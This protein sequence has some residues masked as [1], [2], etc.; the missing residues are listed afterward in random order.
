MMIA[1]VKGRFADINGV[2]KGDVTNPETFELDVTID[3]AS[4][5]TRQDQRDAH[6]RSPDFFDVQ[7]WPT[8]RFVGK[9][10]EGDPTGEFTLV[11]D[12]TIRDVTR[13]LRLAV[14]NEGSVVDPW[15]N[16][17]LGFSANGKIKRSDFGLT[18]NQVLEAGGLAVGD[19]IRISV[20][21]EFTA[22]TE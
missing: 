5:D 8:I 17:R 6:L 10:I 21:V 12:I 3:A 9:E 7:K 16:S 11:G 1:T 15:G 18:W 2:L 13:E 4:I 20:D 22:V 19:D 14:T